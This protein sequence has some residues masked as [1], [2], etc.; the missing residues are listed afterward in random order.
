MSLFITDGCEI[1]DSYDVRPIPH[2]VTFGQ[3]YDGIC[4]DCWREAVDEGVLLN[5]VAVLPS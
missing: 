1:C 4:A 3:L 5:P 2:V